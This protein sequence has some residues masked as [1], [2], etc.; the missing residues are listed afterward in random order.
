MTTP[1]AMFFI[2]PCT[3]DRAAQRETLLRVLRER[4]PTAVF[5]V[6]VQ[7]EGDPVDR[8]MMRNI[9]FKASGAAGDDVV[10]FHDVDII[11]TTK[12]PRGYPSPRVGEVL[13]LYGHT[14][15]LGWVVVMRAK[16]FVSVDGY[17]SYPTWG[18]ED[19]ALEKNLTA[20]GYL[21]SRGGMVQRWGQGFAELNDR[22]A[23]DSA[24]ERV[25]F[26][27]K[28]RQLGRTPPRV[29]ASKGDLD[30]D[31]AFNSRYVGNV[32]EVEVTIPHV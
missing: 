21:I 28:L 7:T 13:H 20:A 8:G 5:V 6:V 2:I 11:P 31:L 24:G 26:V 1:P 18:S 30:R 27:A 3:R 17:P 12:Y 32:L 16:T 25:K 4:H 23:A 9:G 29:H 19:V 22:G 14:H 10:C 15:C